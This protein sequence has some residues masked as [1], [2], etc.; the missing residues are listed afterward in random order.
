[1]SNYSQ[2]PPT[3][4]N[5]DIIKQ[6]QY[7]RSTF[8]EH[9]TYNIIYM[10]SSESSKQISIRCIV[11]HICG[12]LAV[13]WIFTDYAVWSV[14]NLFMRGFSALNEMMPMR[15]TMRLAVGH[16]PLMFSVHVQWMMNMNYVYAVRRSN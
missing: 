15:M 9:Y 11:L 1:M 8:L 3:T 6:C 5:K 12:D 7:F 14:I 16:F 4:S 13:L 10:E 2:L